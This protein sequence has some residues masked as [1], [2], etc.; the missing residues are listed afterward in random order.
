MKEKH[1]TVIQI[2]LTAEEKQGMEFAAGICGIS[3]SAWTRERLRH[4]AIREL[5]G[6][7]RKVPFIAEIPLGGL[8]IKIRK[9]C[10]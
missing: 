1:N 3:L 10:R 7:G 4:S 8:S 5:E 9:A 6:A 2:R